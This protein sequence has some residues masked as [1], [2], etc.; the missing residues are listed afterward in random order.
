[1]TGEKL[2]DIAA[3]YAAEHKVDFNT[4]VAKLAVERP[5]LFEVMK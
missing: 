1:L 4:A 5:E 3:A 2:V